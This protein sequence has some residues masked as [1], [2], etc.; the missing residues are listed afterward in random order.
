MFFVES[1]I[2]W[3]NLLR[4]WTLLYNNVTWIPFIITKAAKV[5]HI[6][7]WLLS[8]VLLTDPIIFLGRTVTNV[9]QIL[10][11]YEIVMVISDSDSGQYMWHSSHTPTSK[12]LFLWAFPAFKWSPACWKA[13][14]CIQNEFHFSGKFVWVTHITFPQP[15]KI[16]RIL[17]DNL[18]L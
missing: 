13:V 2:H 16:S 17:K 9:L 12:W 15:F 5:F 14:I 3:P 4:T 10:K 11:K 8:F 18:E 7:I 6:Y 1:T